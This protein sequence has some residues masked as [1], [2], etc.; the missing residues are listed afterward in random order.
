MVPQRRECRQNDYL[1]MDILTS[2]GPRLECAT[3]LQPRRQQ[4]K[5]APKL[6]PLFQ[7]NIRSY[8]RVQEAEQYVDRRE[9]RENRRVNA[10]SC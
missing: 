1:T 2:L 3:S 9:T 6:V 8:Q 5:L 4:T 10:Y 7:R